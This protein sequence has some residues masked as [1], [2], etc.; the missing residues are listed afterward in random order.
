MIRN[1]YFQDLSKRIKKISPHFHKTSTRHVF[2]KNVHLPRRQNT[3]SVIR[4][5][6]VIT[7][8]A[9]HESEEMEFPTESASSAR[10]RMARWAYR[11]VV[12]TVVDCARS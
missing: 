10:V 5:G 4:S 3:V 7:W 9:W 1:L 2:D 11:L 12:D 8:S 6:A